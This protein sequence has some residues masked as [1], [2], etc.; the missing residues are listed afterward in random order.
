VEYDPAIVWGGV[1]NAVI[2]ERYVGELEGAKG[3]PDV[4]TNLAND[5][6][7]FDGVYMEGTE[8]TLFWR[9]WDWFNELEEVSVANVVFVE[10]ETTIYVWVFLF[11][12]SR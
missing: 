2:G 6:I 11:W 4:D 9:L 5:S 3:Q 7:V 1:G 10:R 8:C 12:I